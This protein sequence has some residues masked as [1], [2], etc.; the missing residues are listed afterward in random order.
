MARIKQLEKL[1]L[2]DMMLN[3]QSYIGLSEGLAQLPLPLYI[4]IGFK[5]LIIP[6]D[7]DEFTNN[8]CYGQRLFMVRKEDNDFG[9]ILRTLDGY[10][11]PIL[12][13]NKW[14][15]EKA[16]LIGKKII[17][18]KAK[19]LYPVAMHLITLVGE[20]ADRE[21]KLLHREPSKI[22]KAA[23]IEKLNVFSELNALDF[24]RDAMKI[25]VP[26]VLLTP[27][28]ECLVRFMIAKE[29]NAF[30][31]RYFDLMKEDSKPKS[32]FQ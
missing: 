3:L 30:Q 26:E 9:V 28:N 8:I 11:Y 4:D 15:E 18:C 5:R 19:D 7:L 17:T 27:Y 1:T 21:Q 13:N 16:L 32:K 20:M 2:K 31:E 6:K 29:T 14:D 22:E 24:L 10:Y 12:T 25:T 23:G